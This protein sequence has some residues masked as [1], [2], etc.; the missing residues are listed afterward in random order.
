MG[1]EVAVAQG[2]GI[3]EHL[4]AADERQARPAQWV[5][6]AGTVDDQHARPVVTA[7]VDGVLGHFRDE[8]DRRT[9]VVSG[10]GDDAAV[11]KSVRGQRRE[12][13]DLGGRYQRAGQLRVGWER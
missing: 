8:D 5:A 2:A 10:V 13:G 3:V 1:L 12:G 7:S 6:V 9:G 11:G 4:Q